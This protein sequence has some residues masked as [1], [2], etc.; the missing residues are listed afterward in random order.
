MLT[1]GYVPHLPNDQWKKE[2]VNWQ[3][4]GWAGLAIT[5][6]DVV[7]GAKS[8]DPV[9]DSYT[10]KPATEGERLLCQSFKMRKAGSFACVTSPS[11]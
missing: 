2:L 10:L 6:M 3:N 5:L 11:Q 1:A 8:R 9:A 7:V 4:Y